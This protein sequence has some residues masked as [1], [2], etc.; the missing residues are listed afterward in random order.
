MVKVLLT[1]ATSSFI[2]GG[3]EVFSDQLNKVFGDIITIS[4]NNTIKN[5]ASYKFY[6]P[7]LKEPKIAYLIDKYF[8]DKYKEISPELIFVNGMYGWALPEKKTRAPIINILHGGYAPFADSALPKFSLD[9]FRNR[10]IYSFFER[11]SA[12][13][14]KLRISNSN[15]TRDQIKN[16]YGLDSKVVNPAIDT[17]IFRPINKNK[18]IKKLNLPQNK[19]IALFVGRPNYAKGF[20][21]IVKLAKMCPHINFVNILYPPVNSTN[22]N[23]II[24]SFVPHQKMVEYFSAADFLLWPSRF[25]GFGFVPL[26]ALSCNIPVIAFRTGILN[27]INI[28]GI[29]YV[30]NNLAEEYLKIINSRVY[31]QKISSR[32]YIKKNFSFNKFKREFKKIAGEVS[33]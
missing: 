14:A 26:E 33:K 1:F 7:P 9:Y 16:Y 32:K 30:K 8:I 25:E 12:K 17:N 10:F 2:P 18:A 19:K 11:L 29:Y 31:N 6:F 23:M 4:L 22:K 24:K 5:S 15:F 27:E 21:I 20:D 28:K 3:V 13:K